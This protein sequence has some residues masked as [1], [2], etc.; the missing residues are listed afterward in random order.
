MVMFDNIDSCS[1]FNAQSFPCKNIKDGSGNICIIGT[2]YLGS[3]IL[4]D[5]W[6]YVSDVAQWIDE[7]IIYFVET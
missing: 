3:K 7:Q 4:D 2:V 6:N 1:R 5:N